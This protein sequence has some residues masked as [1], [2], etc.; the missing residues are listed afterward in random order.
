MSSQPKQLNLIE[1]IEHLLAMGHAPEYSGN[2]L[3][4]VRDVFANFE[5]LSDLLKRYQD[6]HGLEVSGVLD[7][8]T[9]DRLHTRRCALPDVMPVGAS[10][11]QWPMRD[12]TFFQ[13][14]AYPGV[15]PARVAA[16]YAEA[17]RRLAAVCGI[18]AN[19]V[20]D[21]TEAHIV[22]V[23]GS[24]DGPGNILAESELPC[25]FSAQS[26]AHQ[27]FDVSDG[28]TTLSSDELMIACMCHECGH[29]LG[30]AHEPIGSGSLMEPILRPDISSPQAVDAQNL[31]ARYG[32][33]AAAPATTTP[34]TT[35]ANG[36]GTLPTSPRSKRIAPVS[37]NLNL[38]E[39]GTYKITIEAS[40]AA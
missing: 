28:G 13:Q 10:L 29:A 32:A 2:L 4:A 24:I 36:G 9:I 22:A 14:I 35:T 39:P 17:W 27:T 19:Q 34:T 15:D 16:N 7:Q 23:A 40:D 18:T 26:V 3:S 30:L 38:P 21:P 11:C 5:K 8:R 12:L 6:W 1:I 20:S 33:P 25:G 37:F 31:Q